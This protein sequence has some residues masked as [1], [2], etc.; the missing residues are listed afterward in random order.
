MKVHAR[1]TNN[2]KKLKIKYIDNVLTYKY[3][4]CIKSKGYL[5]FRDNIN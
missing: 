2:P 4:W 3:D 1:I 5:V